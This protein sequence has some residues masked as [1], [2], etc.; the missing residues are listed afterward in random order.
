[1]RVS[2]AE[3]APAAA[4]RDGSDLF[5]VN[6]N[7]LTGPIALTTS[8]LELP[9]FRGGDGVRKEQGACHRADTTNAG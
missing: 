3:G 9:A 1:M 5:D 4:V 6:M 2:A 7:Q 8:D